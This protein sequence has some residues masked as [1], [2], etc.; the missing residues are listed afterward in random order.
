MHS[1]GL[2]RGGGGGVQHIAVQKIHGQWTPCVLK[3]D[4]L[5]L[6]YFDHFCK[7]QN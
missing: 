5:I 7:N 6:S 3:S 2:E 1:N 4:E